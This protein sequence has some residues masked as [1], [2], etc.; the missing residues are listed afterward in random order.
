MFAC[1]QLH[2][3]KYSYVILR[4]YMQFYNF[5]YLFLFYDNYLFA[6]SYMVL[7]IIK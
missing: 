6:H 4:I 1:T 2:D 3:F 7:N 5:K